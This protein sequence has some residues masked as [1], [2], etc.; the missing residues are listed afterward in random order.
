MANDEAM[1]KLWPTQKKTTF[2]KLTQLLSKHLF[3][4]G[5]VVRGDDSGDEDEE[6]GE[7]AEEGEREG[8]E[9][10]KKDGEGVQEVAVALAAE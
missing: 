5:E 4:K 6:G 3:N 2:F 9:K 10:E 7:G 8:K 1:K